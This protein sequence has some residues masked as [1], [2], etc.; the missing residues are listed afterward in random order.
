MVRVVAPSRLHFGL[1]HLPSL[2]DGPD[3]RRFGG[4]GM[5]IDRPG[6]AIEV[7][8]ADEW[9]ATGP[10]AER[11]LAFAKQFA[12][13]CQSGAGFPACQTAEA[14]RN[15]C[16]TAV[17]IRVDRC[18]PQHAGLGTGT[19]LGLAMAAAQAKLLNLEMSAVDL[20]LRAGRGVRSAIGVYGFAQGG[21]LVDAG[22][23]QEEA[24][25]PLAAR[26]DFPDDWR[27]VLC[28]PN[29]GPGV[30][31]VREQEAFEQM[32]Q[33]AGNVQP[34]HDM[35]ALIHQ[36]M[37]P[38]LAA[39]DVAAFGETLYEYNRRAGEMFRPWQGGVY[40]HPLVEDLI[41]M[42]RKLGVHGVGQSSWGPATFAI[43]ADADAA[44][45]IKAE[46]QKQ[47]ANVQMIECR[48]VN[49]GAQVG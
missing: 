42:L 7:H 40:C 21:F 39:Q 31:G 11:A 14:D 22:K 32:A 29:L 24:I 23:T 43:V 38:A 34:M 3:A 6:V 15:V 13:R 25:A 45:H 47:F 35:H 10:A 1:L 26:L 17:A 48:A 28:L 18:A 4:V 8:Q 30:H 9:S 27:I 46:V 20:A 37:L 41:G 19:Q 12:R 49:R 2:D 36:G 33:R 44:T 16:P 5:M